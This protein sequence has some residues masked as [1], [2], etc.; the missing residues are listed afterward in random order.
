MP[1]IATGQVKLTRVQTSRIRSLVDGKVARAKSAQKPATRKPALAHK[2]IRYFMVPLFT[3]TILRLSTTFR[4][5]TSV[6]AIDRHHPLKFANSSPI[7]LRIP[8]HLTFQPNH[9]PEH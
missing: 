8:L 3:S 9:R 5:S 7:D 2:A 1:A 4:S 6:M